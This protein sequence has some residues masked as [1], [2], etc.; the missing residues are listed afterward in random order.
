MR[1]IGDVSKNQVFTPNGYALFG[2][3]LDGVI[4]RASIGILGDKLY[5]T[6]VAGFNAAGVPILGAYH[7]Y[8][9][10]ID[11][12]MQVDKFYEVAQGHFPIIDIEEQIE[13]SA[14]LSL[15]E[16]IKNKFGVMPMI[17]GRASQLNPITGNYKLY[18]YLFWVAHYVDY[19]RYTPE[20][21]PEILELLVPPYPAVPEAADGWDILQ[22]SSKGEGV[23]FGLDYIQS[24][25][26][27]LSLITE[28]CYAKL[29]GEHNPG[30]EFV[31]PQTNIF[32]TVTSLPAGMTWRNLRTRPDSIGTDQG[33]VEGRVYLGHIYPC[34]RE[35]INAEGKWYLVQL[36]DQSFGWVLAEVGNSIFITLTE[37]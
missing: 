15:L 36:P 1:F 29:A 35:V 8:Y 27:D 2:Q 13:L 34:W 16:K 5:K 25:D 24:K 20:M 23:L 37:E 14:L 26:L 9:P 4:L 28:E 18:Q 32:A 10:G 11:I 6:H 22:F 3:H 19:R 7:Y 31:F 33:L 17:Y 21:L 12:Q 30:E